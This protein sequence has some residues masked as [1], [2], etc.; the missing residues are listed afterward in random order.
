MNVASR[1]L[2]VFGGGTLGAAVARL[3]ASRGAAVTVASRT[4]R[5]HAGW[6][7][8][9]AIGGPEPLGWV[10][11]E[12]GVVVAIGPGDHERGASVW[13]PALAGWLPR[14]RTLRPAAIVL[15]G[16]A[17]L[18]GGGLNEFEQSARVARSLG[19]AVVRVPALLAAGSGWAGSLAAGLRSGVR[20]RVSTALP[21]ARALVVEDA[22][23]A[24]LAELGGEADVTV[25]GPQRLSAAA[26]VAALSARYG[27]EVRGRLLGSGLSRDTLSRLD[28]Q[29]SIE[30]LWEEARYGAR[31]S[32]ASWVERLPGPRRRRAEG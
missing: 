9:H 24:V 17:G 28:A 29:A 12:A 11:A 18:G 25:S 31:T 7:R 26:V 27:Q 16:P 2:V 14:L 21:E 32:L 5:E 1:P 23:R 13:G 20:P 15:V 19:A 6:W 3:A 4:A 10:P 8:H 22:A 30:D